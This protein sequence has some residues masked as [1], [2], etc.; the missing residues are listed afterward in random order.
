MKRDKNFHMWKTTKALL[1]RIVDKEQRNHFKN[2]MIDAQIAAMTP[3]P[4][5]EKKAAP[6]VVI[7]GIEVDA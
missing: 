5:K 7:T 3:P 1:S 2:M 4:K 6:G